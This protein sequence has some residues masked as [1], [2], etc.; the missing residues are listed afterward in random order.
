MDRRCSP[1]H[2]V[3]AFAE[4]QCFSGAESD[5]KK[6]VLCE[7]IKKGLNLV[8]ITTSSL[9]PPP[10]LQNAKIKP[11]IFDHSILLGTLVFRVARSACGEIFIFVRALD[12][13]S[14]RK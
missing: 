6:L 9:P 14:K 2:L 13:L 7:K 4:I 11:S 5:K 1:K 3:N 12:D 10:S 8:T